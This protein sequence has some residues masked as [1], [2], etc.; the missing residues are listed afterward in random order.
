MSEVGGGKRRPRPSSLPPSSFVHLDVMLKPPE[1]IYPL[2]IG[3]FP[4]FM[5]ARWTDG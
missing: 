1:L 5:M 4:V 2:Q 3:T